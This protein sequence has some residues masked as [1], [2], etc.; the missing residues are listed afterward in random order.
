M[1]E[2]ALLRDVLDIMENNLIYADLENSKHLLIQR[3]ILHVDPLQ[4]EEKYLKLIVEL[5]WEIMDS[6]GELEDDGDINLDVYN[7]VYL[8]Q[9]IIDWRFDH[10]DINTFIKGKPKDSDTTFDYIND[11]FI[12]HH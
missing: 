11:I 4:D 9:K 2:Y 5:F 10:I 3:M 12:F 1:A 7:Y 6:N 8:F